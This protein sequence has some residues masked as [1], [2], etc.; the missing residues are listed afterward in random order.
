MTQALTFKE[1]NRLQLA[2]ADERH[3]PIIE[4]VLEGRTHAEVA[5]MFGVTRPRVT[6]IMTR[7]RDRGNLPK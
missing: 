2:E 1:H 4:A 5:R 7:A 3:R 6:Q